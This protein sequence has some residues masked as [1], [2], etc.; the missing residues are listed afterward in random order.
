[1][2]AA[3]PDNAVDTGGARLALAVTWPQFV[4]LVIVACLAAMAG[5]GWTLFALLLVAIALTMLIANMA[6]RLLLR[7]RRPGVGKGALL[8]LVVGAL[9]SALSIAAAY[10][11]IHTGRSFGGSLIADL[12]YGSFLAGRESTPP[13]PGFDRLAQFAGGLIFVWLMLIASVVALSIPLLTGLIGG[14]SAG[15]RAR[16]LVEGPKPEQIAG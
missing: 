7:M 15:L 5:Y 4:V 6:W 16:G 11:D 2:A 9:A 13:N 14:M 12:L 8:G 1:M 10:T 3:V